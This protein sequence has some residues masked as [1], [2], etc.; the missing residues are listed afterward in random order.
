VSQRVT[1]LA[2]T[3][4]PWVIFAL[5][6]F[7]GALFGSFTLSVATVTMIWII[8]AAGLNISMGYG[9]VVNFG[10][11]AFYGVGAY[12]AAVLSVNYHVNFIL[13]L[14]AGPVIAAAAASLI[15]P[16]IL[17][18]TQHM[19]F[20]IMTLAIGVIADDIFNNVRFLGGPNGIAGVVFPSLLQG[21]RASYLFI[22]LF[23]ALAIAL[24]QFLGRNHFGAVLRGLRD[25]VYL[26]R[27]LGYRPLRYKSAA[28]VISAAIAGLAGVMYA[29]YISFVLPTPFGLSGASF[30]AFAIVAFGGMGTIWGPVVAA[31]LL[32]A[33][34]EYVNVPPNDTLLFYGAAILLVVVIVPE[35]IGPGAGRLTRKLVKSVFSR[36]QPP[37]SADGTAGRNDRGELAA[38]GEAATMLAP[39]DI[40]GGQP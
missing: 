31:F 9:G 13:V 35:G 38:Q 37:G 2:R 27:S 5:V 8:L 36:S 3:G 20:A 26:A 12:T 22:A 14:I 15:G 23:A 29:Y 7:A 30:E 18:R 25:D 16:V 21:A 19:Q 32:T 28:F 1:S 10:I 11:G 33:A 24:C 39:G 40:G 4:V 34:D 6:V 17:A